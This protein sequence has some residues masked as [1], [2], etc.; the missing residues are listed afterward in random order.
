MCVNANV[1]KGLSAIKVRDMGV[2]SLCLID[3]RSAKVYVANHIE[4]SINL[5]SMEEVLHFIHNGNI[6]KPIL[7]VCFSSRRARKMAEDI[8]GRV[9]NEIYYLDCGVMELAGVLES[10]GINQ[11]KDSKKIF[12]DDNVTSK[13]LSVANDFVK[14][15]NSVNKIKTES[16]EKKQIDTCTNPKYETKIESTPPPPVIYANH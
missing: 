6:T 13:I 15:H 12:Q 7:F 10:L 9:S 1:A 16:K 5:H 3:L 8:V 4:H 11:D 2:D 14:T